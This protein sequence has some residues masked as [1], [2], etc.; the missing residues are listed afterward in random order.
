MLEKS[1][2]GAFPIADVTALTSPIE[3]QGAQPCPNLH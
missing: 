1:S 3:N 2:V